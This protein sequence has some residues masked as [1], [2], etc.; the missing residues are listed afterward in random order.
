[1]LVHDINH[2]V[3]ES[4]KGKQQDKEE[5]REEDVLAVVSDEHTLFIDARLSGNALAVIHN[6]PAFSYWSSFFEEVGH[7]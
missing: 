5:E 7:V 1:V 3:A 4:P 6:G 2:P